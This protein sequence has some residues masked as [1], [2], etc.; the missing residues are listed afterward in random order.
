MMRGVRVPQRRGVEQAMTTTDTTR[1]IGQLTLHSTM[2]ETSVIQAKPRRLGNRS[3]AG[4]W[5]FSIAIRAET[6]TA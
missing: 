5:N 4:T 1:A 6:V 3:M 2:R